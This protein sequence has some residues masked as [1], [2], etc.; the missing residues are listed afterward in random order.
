[1]LQ[2][3][4]LTKARIAVIFFLLFGLS[5]ALLTLS[6][7]SD[8]GNESILRIMEGPLSLC[9]LMG[10]LHFTMLTFKSRPKL[11]LT[12]GI[13]VLLGLAAITIPFAPMQFSDYHVSVNKAQRRLN[14]WQKDGIVAS[15]EVALGNPVGDKKQVG[16]GKTPL[17]N[18]QIVDKAPS[19]FHLWLGI[20][21]P[22][23]DD[24]WSGRRAGQIS[25]L[26]F[27][28]IRFENLN[29]RIPYS[30]SALGGAIGIHGGGSDND[31][32]LGCVALS[33]PDVEALFAKLP[34]GTEVRIY[35]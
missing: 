28:Y 21:Y 11:Q 22:N 33:N 5:E 16:D 30:S 18:Y 31:W 10:G 1:M 14:V 2:K 26:E 7:F 12:L 9:F 24:A 29:G 19:Q 17:G 23:N 8:P 15:Y 32:T 20:N 3:P 4:R 27:A 13:F 35:P 34:V 25:W 6:A